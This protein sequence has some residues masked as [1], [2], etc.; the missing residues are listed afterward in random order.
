MKKIII[1]IV[2][3][4]M[5][6]MCSND[7]DNKNDN[8]TIRN[9]FT[10]EQIIDSVKSDAY[11]YFDEKMSA[12]EFVYTFLSYVNKNIFMEID[13]MDDI[14]WGVDDSGEQIEVIC[15]YKKLP[16]LVVHIPMKLRDGKLVYSEGSYI[17][18]KE[19][20]LKTSLG[21]IVREN[22]AKEK[23]IKT[24]KKLKINSTYFK[25]VPL[26]QVL[27]LVM[28][29]AG[30]STREQDIEWDCVIINDNKCIVTA[31]D[32]Q[33]MDVSIKC[34]TIGD[35]VSVD[36][37]DVNI[38]YYFK[39]SMTLSHWIFYYEAKKAQSEYRSF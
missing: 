15:S 24:V 1:G 32:S 26:P 4:L 10:N 3:L 14:Q 20:N 39:S 31:T 6:V 28:Q 37:D 8:H 35:S 33:T 7:D 18:D 29:R 36:L 34:T 9:S 23:F 17:L 22:T 25:D 19:F 38:E 30:S 16:N 27:S 5:F 12:S 13:N 21:Q 11:Y 2:V